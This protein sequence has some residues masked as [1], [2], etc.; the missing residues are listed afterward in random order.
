[1]RI[2]IESR[3]NGKVLWE[4][5][6]ESIREAVEKAKLNLAGAELYRAYLLK[7]D[8]SYANLAGAN[9]AGANLFRADLS[10]ADLSGA[11]LFGADL[12]HAKLSS[13]N[14]FMA[15][16]YGTDLFEADLSQAN[17]SRADLSHAS[18]LRAKLSVN[19]PPVNSHQFISEILWRAADDD[20]KRD[21]AARVRMQTEEC[22]EY[23]VKLAKEKNVLEWA[24][25]ILFKWNEFEKKFFEVEPKNETADGKVCDVVNDTRQKKSWCENLTWPGWE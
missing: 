3:W 4:G 8:L 21:F 6:V 22:W 10:M 14:L 25:G 12:R 13:A 23:F 15:N 20:A 11:Y 9:L 24:R 16:L 1:M 18:L 7:A 5:E 17:L 2:Q 19:R